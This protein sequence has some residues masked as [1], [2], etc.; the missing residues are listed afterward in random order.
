MNLVN[1]Y[2]NRRFMGGL[3]SEFGPKVKRFGWRRNAWFQEKLENLKNC[4]KKEERRFLEIFKFV[5]QFF[6]TSY[7]F[8]KKLHTP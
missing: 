6:H 3:Y 2:L 4:P 5:G 7:F 8:S 1:L